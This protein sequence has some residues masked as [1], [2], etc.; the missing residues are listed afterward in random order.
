M[1]KL[2]ISGP[3]FGLV[4]GLLGSAWPSTSS[5]SGRHSRVPSLSRHR[6][7]DVDV[8]EV[9]TFQSR[10]KDRRCLTHSVGA[11][12]LSVLGSEGDPAVLK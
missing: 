6:I 10:F 4:A 2:A 8:I 12:F 1:R 5:H 7:M 3:G 11:V 9:V